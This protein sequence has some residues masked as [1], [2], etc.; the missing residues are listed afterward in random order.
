MWPPQGWRFR[1]PETGWSAPGGQTFG[2]VVEAIPHLQAA[3]D[4]AP[5]NANVA[6]LLG[7]ALIDN[8]RVTEGVPYL[9]RAAL[10]DPQYEDEYE[11]AL[12]NLE[13]AEKSSGQ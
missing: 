1:Q 2:Q 13:Q 6:H 4:R 3:S 5:D 9:Y 11:H 8:G 7:T 12:A 10:L